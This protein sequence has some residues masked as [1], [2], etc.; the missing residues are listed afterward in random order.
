MKIDCSN[1]EQVLNK[2]LCDLPTSWRG[3]LVDVI[4]KGIC[5]DFSF[6]CEDVENCETLTSISDFTKTGDKISISFVD[7]EKKSFTRAFDISTILNNALNTVDPK[8]MMS[9]QDWNKLSYKSKLQ[10]IIN[11]E[12]ECKC[13][14]TTTTTSTTTTTTKAPKINTLT[15][16]N[17][18]LHEPFN[19]VLKGKD[20]TTNY[21]VNN[22]TV[23]L[24]TKVIPYTGLEITSELTIKHNPSVKVNI[25]IYANNQEITEVTELIGQ[26]KII[27]IPGQSDIIVSLL[28]PVEET[29]TSTTTQP[30]T[31]TSTTTSSS[32]TTTTTV[33]CPKVVGITV[34][35][36]PEPSTTTTTTACNCAS[37]YTFDGTDC[38]KTI[39]MAPDITFTNYCLAP[40]FLAEYSQYFSRIYKEGFSSSS[41]SQYTA[42]VSDVFAEMNVAPQWRSISNATGPMN[43]AGVWIDSDCNGTKDALGGTVSGITIENAGTAYTNGTYFNVPLK[44]IGPYLYSGATADVFVE[45]DI[46]ASVTLVNGGRSYAV[47]DQLTIDPGAIGGTGGGLVIKVTNVIY[48]KATIAFAYDNP[49]AERTVYVGIG[50]DNQFELK[51][52]GESI[53][54]TLV[55]NVQQN[56]KIWHIFPVTLRKGSNYF[57]AV[58]IGD[59]SVN[60]A[61]GM[62]I[63]DDTK[64]NLASSTSDSDL[65]IMFTSSSLVGQHIDVATCQAGWTLDTSGGQGNYLCKKIVHLGCGEVES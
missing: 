35:L 45:N 61:I 54:K 24:D 62:T 19:I 15:V 4:C 63:Y 52:N 31:T 40:S 21:V 50:A 6:K 36:E 10:A 29:T 25:L 16:Q 26:K 18:T 2:Y 51:V 58:A 38:V 32:T 7:E 12:A 34:E 14:P 1:C 43:R 39:T 27:G 60:D 37:G 49:D 41:I 22:N 46:V 55:T 11:Y 56:F 20:Q 64:E 59:G 13:C 23:S 17:Y 53:A 3:Q 30:P 65:H 33:Q 47:N 5:D 57:N 42:P 9:Q 48:Q 28:T 8:C 44:F